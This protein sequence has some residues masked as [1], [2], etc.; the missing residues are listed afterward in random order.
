V[1]YA[2]VGFPLLIAGCAWLFGRQ[3]MPPAD[4]TNFLPVVDILIAALNEEDVIAAR[5]DNALACDYPADRLQIVIA[6][7]GSTDCTAEI[8]RDYEARFPGRVKLLDYAERRGKATALNV[9]LPQLDG[10]IAVLSDANTFFDEQ[11]VRHL[12]RWFAD[13]QVGSV[14]GKLALVDPQ[15]GRNVD[16]LYWQYE[17]LLKRC[18]NRLGALLGSNGAIY[19]IRRGQYVPIPTDTI[20][21][22]FTIPILIKLCHGGRLVYDEAALASEETAADLTAEFRRRSRIGAGGFQSLSRVWKL[23]LPIHGWTSFAFL[24]H[25]M[26]R[27]FC[28]AFLALA[29]ATNLLLIGQPVYQLTMAAQA[30]FYLAAIL[31][32]LLPGRGTAIRLLRL[33]TLFTSMNLALVVGFWRWIVGQQGGTWQRTAR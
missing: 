18:E 12:V 28:P 26:M 4:S 33:T 15:S 13:P 10:E 30:A 19:A 6:S 21:D 32:S 25:K 20:I 29:L 14:C 9:S 17:N 5:L 8:V 23:V 7:D 24:S 22:D 2:Y 1:A 16:S 3:P 31:G 27:W 11:A